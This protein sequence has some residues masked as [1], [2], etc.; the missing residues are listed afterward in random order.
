MGVA[1]FVLQ[2]CAL[3]GTV[4][5]DILDAHSVLRAIHLGKLQTKEELAMLTG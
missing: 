3:A 2:V 1:R 4:Y 5:E